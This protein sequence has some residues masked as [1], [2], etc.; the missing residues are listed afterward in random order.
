MNKIEV[1]NNTINI[2]IPESAFFIIAIVIII[3][4]GLYFFN[5]TK[6]Q[7]TIK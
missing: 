2:T 7:N 6:K 3:A 4:I 5:G 1:S